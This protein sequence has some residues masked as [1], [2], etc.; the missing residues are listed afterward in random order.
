MWQLRRRGR[1]CWLLLLTMAC[2]RTGIDAKQVFEPDPNCVHVP[3]GLLARVDRTLSRESVTAGCRE[4]GPS[5]CEQCCDPIK[6]LDGHADCLVLSARGEAL[7]G[8][9]C[10]RSCQP[11]ARCTLKAEATL[12]AFQQP[13]D[14]ACSFPLQSFG[15]DPTMPCDLYC[16]TLQAAALSCPYLVCLE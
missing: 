1:G 8:A 10:Q 6:S 9:P 13:G 15:I 11:C 16:H 3:E 12:R 14:C 5:G 7:T 2:G 4:F